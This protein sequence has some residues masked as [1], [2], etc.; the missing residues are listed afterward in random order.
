MINILGQSNIFKGNLNVAKFALSLI[1]MG[2]DILFMVQHYI[3][4]KGSDEEKLNVLNKRNHII[5]DINKAPKRELLAY[6]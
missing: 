1:A 5:Y 4:Y 2:F 3:L 6:G